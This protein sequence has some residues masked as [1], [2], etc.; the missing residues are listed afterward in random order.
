MELIGHDPSASAVSVI[1]LDLTGAVID[2]AFG[3][4]TLE[5]IVDSVESWGADVVFAGLSPLAETV[6]ET[7]E[8]Q[9]LMVRKDLHSAIAAAFQITESQRTLL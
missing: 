9:P 6:V 7:L 1:V 3:A 5:R 8:H 4:A 2:D